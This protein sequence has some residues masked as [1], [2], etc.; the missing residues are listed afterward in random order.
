[1]TQ[2]VPLFSG[3]IPTS[4]TKYIGVPI[5]R[6]GNGKVL[7]IDIGW[8]DATTAATITL[9]LTSRN[10]VEAPV[11]TAGTADMWKDSGETFAGP[12]GS[13]IGGGG[14]YVSNVQQQRA[15]LKI[16]TT[17]TSNFVIMDGAS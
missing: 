17:A 8:I 14:I 1:M 16:V 4:T 12:D 11:E 3:L 13:A 10:S 5:Y 2:R 7:G 15:R 9:E 6:S